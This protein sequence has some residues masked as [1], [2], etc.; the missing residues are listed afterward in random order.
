MFSNFFHKKNK[1]SI[2]GLK[3][4]LTILFKDIFLFSL[5]FFLLLLILEDIKPGFVVFWFNPLNTFYILL[6]SLLIYLILIFL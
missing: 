5:C 1:K 4:A 6:P 3:R 2:P